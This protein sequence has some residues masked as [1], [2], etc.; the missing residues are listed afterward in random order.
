MNGQ[1]EKKSSPV[2]IVI[3]GLLFC[4]VCVLIGYIIGTAS[5]DSNTKEQSNE[6]SSPI[7]SPAPST[8]PKATSPSCPALD[9]V[10]ENQPESGEVLEGSITSGYESSLT[11]SSASRNDSYIILEYSFRPE[12]EEQGGLQGLRA[13]LDSKY[14]SFYVRANDDIRVAVPLGTA[15]IYYAS[16]KTWYGTDLKFGD[17]TVY[18]T[19]DDLFDF[20]NYTYNITLYPVSDGDMY[21]YE[22]SP[23]DFPK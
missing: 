13:Y 10:F 6:L 7:L 23:E 19:S 12:Q 8:T 14:Y 4:V 18:S 16:G 9:A 17:D 21:T 3:I 11:V 5:K 2:A 22:I 15:K 20:E 1:E